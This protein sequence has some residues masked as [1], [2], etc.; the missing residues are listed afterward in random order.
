MELQNVSNYF[1]PH[2]RNEKNR[3]NI[4]TISALRF[5]LNALHAEEIQQLHME[6]IRKLIMNSNSS[7]A[8]LF[9]F[10]RRQ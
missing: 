9:A 1:Q 3:W 4:S 7:N 6:I 2:E 8:I 5:Q 10:V